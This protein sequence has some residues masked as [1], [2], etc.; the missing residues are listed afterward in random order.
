M[1]AKILHCV[2]DEKFI[3]GAIELFDS[4]EGYQNEYVIVGKECIRLDFIKSTKVKYVSAEWYK[5]HC[6]E[7]ADYDIVIL[8]SLMS[9][10][11]ELL[12]KTSN[13]IKVIWLS[14]GYDTYE[15]PMPITPLIR[16]SHQIKGDIIT[17][18]KNNIFRVI[19][20]YLFEFFVYRFKNI[21][22]WSNTLKR[23]DYYSGVFPEEYDLLK[24]D[25]RF[26]AIRISYNYVSR[27]SPLKYENFDCFDM[28]KRKNI[29]IGHQA[30]PLLNHVDSFRYIKK[31][32]LP[33][34]IQIICPLSYGPKS[35]IK[36]I[37]EAGKMIFGNQF[38]P[39]LD[40]MP[41][42]EYQKVYNSVN[43][44]IYNIERQCAVGNIL[45]AVW[46]GVRVFLPR[47][48]MNYKHFMNLGIRV[49]SIEDELNLNNIMEKVSTEEIRNNRK[50]L[51]ENYSFDIVR[52]KLENALKSIHT[53]P[54]DQE[55]LN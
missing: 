52:L 43:V 22:K 34:D 17:S 41:F 8:H 48:S 30:N 46:D 38:I 53:E 21:V 55:I 25:R 11:P 33:S 4:I 50:I 2:I 7:S 26:K 28:S 49:Y 47:T 27:Q 5:K 51:L 42:D 14:W 39:L 37:E 36:K 32:N 44:A 9:L 13:K 19:K 24:K 3:D 20:G 1:F 40:F 18:L 16:L 35:E 10:A 29:M 31:L 45:L 23:I 6:I 15:F 12:L 54:D